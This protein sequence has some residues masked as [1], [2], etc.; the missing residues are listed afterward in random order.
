M[1]RTLSLAAVALAAAFVFGQSPAK[2]QKPP[3][4]TPEQILTQMEQDWAMAIVKKDMATLDRI[5]APEWM[6]STPEGELQTKAQNDADLKSGA[7][8]CESMKVDELKV[9]VFGD[10]AV[11]FG[12]GTEKSTYKG[13]D[14]SGQYRFTDVFVKRNGVWMAVATHASKV[15]KH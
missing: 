6:I 9:S 13:Q 12:L 8:N 14:S 15:A 3:S 11:V 10:S 4:G 7:Y 5:V 2:A 1:K